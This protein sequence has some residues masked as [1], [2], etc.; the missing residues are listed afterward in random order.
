MQLG[1]DLVLDP[2]AIDRFPLDDLVV[3]RRAGACEQ[4][5]DVVLGLH[6]VLPQGRHRLKESINHGNESIIQSINQTDRQSIPHPQINPS[7]F[8]TNTLT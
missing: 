5:D 8:M 2:P 3:S 6:W 4:R 7:I 1:A